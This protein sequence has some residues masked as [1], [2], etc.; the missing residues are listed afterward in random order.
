MPALCRTNTREATW[1]KTTQEKPAYS[2]WAEKSTTAGNLI[3]CLMKSGFFINKICKPKWKRSREGITGRRYQCNCRAAS[4]RFRWQSEILRPKKKWHLK[5]KARIVWWRSSW[6]VVRKASL[7]QL[8]LWK[9]IFLLKWVSDRNVSRSRLRCLESSF[10]PPKCS[11]SSSTKA[12]S[13][14][15]RDLKL[16]K[17]QDQR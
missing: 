13:G 15:S 5:L 12:G 9:G 2:T 4:S 14:P 3:T 11:V 16:T 10:R 8:P 7:N 6:S 17:A 1:A